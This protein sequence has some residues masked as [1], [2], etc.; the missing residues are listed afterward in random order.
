MR[1]R[2][3][4]I[5]QVNQHLRNAYLCSTQP[6]VAP[7]AVVVPQSTI[8][9]KGESSRYWVDPTNHM[10]LPRSLAAA[11][12]QTQNTQSK[13]S[14][15]N[16]E[17]P[18]FQPKKVLI[19]SKLTRYEFE[20]KVH[21]GCDD[22]QLA[23][24]L[25]KRGSDYQR[26][27][28]KHKIHHSYLNTL[29]KELEN[30]GIESRLVRRFG[31]TQEAVDW[32]DAV[33]SAGG[34][35]TF[36]MAS[37]KVRTKHKPVIGI[38]TDPQGSEGYMCLM[39]K[40]PEENLSGALK[41][42]FSGNFEWL[43]R[44]RIRITVTGDDGIS[45]AIELHDQQLNRDPATTRWTDNPRSPARENDVEE[46]MSLS[47]PVKK[48]MI[49]ESEDKAIVPIEKET[50]ELPVLAL[51]EV[52]VGESLSSRKSSGITICTGTGSTSWHFNINKLTEQCV[53]DLMKIVAQHCNLPQIPHENK[54]AVSEICTKFNQQ[55]IFDPDRR[56]LA[57]SVR[58]PIFNATF[59]PTDPR[60][61]ADK[62]RIKSRGYDA[63]LVI[64]GGISYRFNDGSEAVMEVRDE[65]TLRTV[66][67]R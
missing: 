6:S 5:E 55:L 52:F 33:F 40:L 15:G 56:Q 30:A 21:K 63:H 44:Q 59:P 67:F 3:R 7:K 4:N 8:V 24:I 18:S 13:R 61:F 25:K 19:L 1:I 34:D 2:I 57:F 20:K 35:G 43:Y 48:R 47:P 16:M 64:D 42:L 65:D 26:L 46:C 27:L 50:V 39:R 12:Y 37:S 10:R 60:G 23:S 9:D 14:I 17:K 49:S 29:Q 51:N 38:N 28:S 45:D 53:Q 31:Y 41:K 11:L 32:A 36:L 58:D 62:I 66:V 54:N 22:D